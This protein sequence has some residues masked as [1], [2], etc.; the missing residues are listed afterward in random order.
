MYMYVKN[1]VI[2]IL[3]KSKIPRTPSPPKKKQTKKQK[4]PKKTPTK[5]Q[6]PGIVFVY[7]FVNHILFQ[8][9][10]MKSCT[11]YNI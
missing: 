7:L 5:Q 11:C 8:S 2:N 9:C 6:T 4:P 1:Y 10:K 3:Q